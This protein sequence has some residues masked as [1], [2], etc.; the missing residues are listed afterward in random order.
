V[1]IGLTTDVDMTEVRARGWLSI[2]PG[3]SKHDRLLFDTHYRRC[4][5]SGAPFVCVKSTPSDAVASCDLQPA[6]LRLTDGALAVLHARVGTAVRVH[7]GRSQPTIE[8][9]F[10]EQAAELAQWLWQFVSDPSNTTDL[11]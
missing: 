6:G 1:T 2:G 5:R 4:E 3:H 8:G 7:G 10:L 9:V 11:S